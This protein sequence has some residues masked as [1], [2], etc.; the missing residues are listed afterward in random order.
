MSIADQPDTSFEV[1]VEVVNVVVVVESIPS[2]L[3]DAS[4]YHLHKQ[5]FPLRAKVC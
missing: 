2:F 5:L 4:D 3:D 1:K